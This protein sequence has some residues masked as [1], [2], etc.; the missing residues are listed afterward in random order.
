MR[1]RGYACACMPPSPLTQSGDLFESSV[2]KHDAGEGGGVL[3][4]GMDVG[5]VFGD[6]A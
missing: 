6:G 3:G 2:R 5:V 1:A 4:S